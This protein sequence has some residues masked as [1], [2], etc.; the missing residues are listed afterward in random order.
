MRRDLCQR[1]GGGRDRHDKKD[2]TGITKDGRVCG[3]LDRCDRRQIGKLPAPPRGKHADRVFIADKNGRVATGCL[4]SRGK[5]ASPAAAAD[6][7][8]PSGHNHTL[9]P[10][11]RG[12]AAARHP[13]QAASADAA[14]SRNHRR[15]GDPIHSRPC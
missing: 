8:R 15:H 12:P 4:Q 6:E 1:L 5:R 7:N 14:R 10:A 3:C 9:M 13:D 2:K 11:P